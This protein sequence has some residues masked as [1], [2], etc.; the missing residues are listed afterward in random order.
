M[1]L[2]NHD[3]RGNIEA[4]ILYSQKNSRWVLPN[5][6]YSFE[7]PAFD[8]LNQPPIHVIVLDTIPLVCPDIEVVIN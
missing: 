7:I 4:Q 2:G 8:H 3:R 5:Y 6:Y 1:T